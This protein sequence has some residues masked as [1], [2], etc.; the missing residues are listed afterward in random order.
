MSIEAPETALQ[1]E[2]TTE[3]ALAVGQRVMVLQSKH[4]FP[5][6]GTSHDL[7]VKVADVSAFE[8]TLTSVNVNTAHISERLDVDG[9]ALPTYVV[10][11]RPSATLDQVGSRRRVRLLQFSI[12]PIGFDQ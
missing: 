2:I 9:N 4:E 8:G 3:T 10:P 11:L 1:P 6:R 7:G 5:E 12:I